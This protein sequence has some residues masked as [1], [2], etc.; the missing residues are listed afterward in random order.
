[1]YLW[2]MSKIEAEDGSVALRSRK[3]GEL[4][5]VPLDSLIEKLTNEVKMKVL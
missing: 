3:D 5:E 4:G 1:M 2:G